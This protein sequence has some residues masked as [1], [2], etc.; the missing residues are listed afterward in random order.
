MK[1]SI[2]LDGA[3]QG[4]LEIDGQLYQIDRIDQDEDNDYIFKLVSYDERA[5]KNRIE[6]N[7]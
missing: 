1:V 7:A 6:E 5:L 3:T 4:Y 2:E